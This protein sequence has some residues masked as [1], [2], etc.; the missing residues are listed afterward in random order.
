MLVLI[1]GIRQMA[2]CSKCGVSAG[3]KLIINGN[4]QES[5]I[6]PA[7]E[8]R[9]IAG[10]PIIGNYKGLMSSREQMQEAEHGERVWNENVKKI[11]EKMEHKFKKNLAEQ[12]SAR[13]IKID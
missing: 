9:K 1:V 11:E 5:Y 10:M 3:Y 2:T 13:N 7:C 6:C 8:P 4:S 12:F